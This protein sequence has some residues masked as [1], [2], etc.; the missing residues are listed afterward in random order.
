MANTCVTRVVASGEKPDAVDLIN[1]YT[2]IISSMM[3][4]NPGP[5]GYD[6]EW[7]TAAMFFDNRGGIGS[8]SRGYIIKQSVAGVHAIFDA[9]AYD[10]LSAVDPDRWDEIPDRDGSIRTSDKWPDEWAE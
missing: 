3:L 5:D 8:K 1:I 6:A 10:E 2:A 7:V 9:I 4:G